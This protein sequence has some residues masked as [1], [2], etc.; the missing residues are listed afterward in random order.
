[1]SNI[2]SNPLFG[3]MLTVVSFYIAGEISRKVKTPLANPLLIATLLCAAVM[4][5]FHISYEDYIEGAQFVSM[6]LLPS[7]AMLGLSVYRQRK[8]LK[9]QFLPV[10]AGCFCGSVLSMVS[11]V[12]LC[13]V[14]LP[15]EV[16]VHSLL[17]KSVTT[18]IALDISEQLGGVDTIT[19]TAVIVCGIGG[20]VIHPLVIKA[21]HLKDSVATGVAMGTASHAIGTAKALEMGE[22]EGAVSGVS[23]GVA[24]ICTVI[25]ALF[26]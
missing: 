12:V 2:T 13:R 22:V 1:M 4:K 23:M 18:A 21:L 11:T 24:G 15:D 8:V 19:L 9:E 25:I 26:L 3:I 17:P 6:F 16:M 5:V 7:T 10:V 20:A 14:F